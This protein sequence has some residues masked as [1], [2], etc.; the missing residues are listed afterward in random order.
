M[1][2]SMKAVS[3]FWSSFTLSGEFEMHEILLT[4]SLREPG[5]QPCQR[6]RTHAKVSKP[7]IVCLAAM[8][9][10]IN[11]LNDHRQF[12]DSEHFVIADVGHVAT[13]A[14]RHTVPPVRLW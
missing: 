10:A 3:R 9:P 5:R 1:C 12:E 11:L 7:F 6:C 4:V 13:G 2:S 8:K 14:P